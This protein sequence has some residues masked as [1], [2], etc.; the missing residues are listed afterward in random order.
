MVGAWAANDMDIKR[1]R[2]HVPTQ[3]LFSCGAS[4]ETKG[5]IVLLTLFC[6]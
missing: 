4:I 6:G 1:S 3:R 2:E 5:K